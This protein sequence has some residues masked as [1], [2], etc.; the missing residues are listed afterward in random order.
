MGHEIFDS[1]DVVEL[2]NSLHWKTIEY[3]SAK[4]SVPAARYGHSMNLYKGNLVVF[5]GEK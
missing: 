5:G 3:I 4:I 1:L 2:E